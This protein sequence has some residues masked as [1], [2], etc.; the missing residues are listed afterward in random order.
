MPKCPNCENILGIWD[1][2]FICP[3]CSATFTPFEGRFFKGYDRF[4]VLEA[5][6]LFEIFLHCGFIKQGFNRIDFIDGMLI[7]DHILH[8]D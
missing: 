5:L 6:E 7:L 4:I 3:K 2:G 8:R 1:G